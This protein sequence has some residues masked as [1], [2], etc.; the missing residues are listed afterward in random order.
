MWKHLMIAVF[1]SASL[2]STGCPALIAGAGAGAGVYTYVEGNL[3]RT[4]QAPFDKALD[5]SMETLRALRMTVIEKPTGDAIKSVIK[6]ER[7]DGTPVTIT[8]NMVSLNITEIGVRSGVV[9]FWDQK[10]SKLV[11]ANIAQRLQ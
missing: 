1:L 11:H 2:L 7:S 10:V 4:Y 8:L 9:G 5:A 3:T 6:A